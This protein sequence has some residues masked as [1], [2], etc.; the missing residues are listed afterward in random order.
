MVG[1]IYLFKNFNVKDYRK[2]DKFRPIDK[3][4]QIVFSNDMKI[5]ALD[6]SDVL[7]EQAVFDFYDLSDLK[8]LSK[9]TTYLTGMHVKFISSGIFIELLLSI[10]F[11]YYYL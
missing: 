11:A 1:N 2:E 5:V 7:I 9:Q 6:E 4:I 10:N 3:D 8:Q